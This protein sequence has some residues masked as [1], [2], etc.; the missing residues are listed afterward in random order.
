MITGVAFAQAEQWQLSKSAHF[1]VH[2]RKADSGFIEQLMD[3]AEKC[4]NTIADELGFRRY[5][6]W[7]W[8]NRAHIYVYDDAGSYRSATGQPEWSV[9]SALPRDKVI[10]TFYRAE[11]FFEMVLPHEMGHIVFREF[12]GTNNPSVPLWLEEG[13]ASYVG[14]L[15]QESVIA[16]MRR[17]M[18]DHSFMSLEALQRFNLSL[19]Q[20]QEAI[21]AFY[22]ESVSVVQY[23]VKS[24]GK[25]S[26]I[27]FLQALRDKKNLN[28]ALASA[29]PFASITELNDAWVKYL[30][31]H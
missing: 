29:Y 1:I 19:A 2:Y 12:V 18:N 13:V 4:Y 31:S 9:G 11:G 22:L 7:L 14:Y 10:Q 6:F 15:N 20:D 17:A 5:D 26:F 3:V 30:Q 28:R 16:A 21:R 23:L 25:D 24:F 8:D 27:T